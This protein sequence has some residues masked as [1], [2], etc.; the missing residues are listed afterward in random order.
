MF[1]ALATLYCRATRATLQ[2]GTR[3]FHGQRRQPLHEEEELMGSA[4]GDRTFSLVAIGSALFTA[5]F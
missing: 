3:A 2:P 5:L 1:L 4:A